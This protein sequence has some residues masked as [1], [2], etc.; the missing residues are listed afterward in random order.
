ME[1]L[2]KSA[3]VFGI[4]I[5][6]AQLYVKPSR[7]MWQGYY[8]EKID[9]KS[10]KSRKRSWGSAVL[11]GGGGGLLPCGVG[12]VG[13]R[14]E[15]TTLAGILAVA[16]GVF[17]RVDDPGRSARARLREA[18]LIRETLSPRT[19]CAAVNSLGDA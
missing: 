6:S 1:Y 18:G 2:R 11:E 15:G 8:F 9:D 7:S 12:G 10:Q 17:I 16:G 3:A 19:W 4:I 14:S 5:C 13:D